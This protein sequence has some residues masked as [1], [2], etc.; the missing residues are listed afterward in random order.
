MR[1]EVIL[2]PVTEGGG[3]LAVGRFG[4]KNQH[5]SLLSFSAD[6]YLNEMG[7][8]SPLQPVENTSNGQ[9]VAAYDAVPD[10]EDLEGDV[11]LFAA[12]M[13]STKAPSRDERLA[14][15][16]DAQAG[17]EIFRAIGCAVCHVPSIVTATPGTQVNA[18]MFVVPEALGNKII[19]PFGDFLMHNIGTGDGIVQNGGPVTRNKMRTAPLW[20]VRTRTRLMHDGQSLT[21]EDAILRH[22]GEA[23][24]TTNE[25]RRLSNRQ[26]AQLFKFL[27][28]L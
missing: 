2:V 28:S 16:R 8:T 24:P 3:A 9:S 21:F 10:P 11:D 5:A 23:S 1:G 4:W 20:G 12:F 15:T 14:T 18:G 26:K 22:E 6:A 27:E 17:E 25:F 13:R 19:H 7:I